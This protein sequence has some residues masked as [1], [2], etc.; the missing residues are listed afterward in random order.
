MY[1]HPY[2]GDDGTVTFQR[3]SASAEPL[4]DPIEF[5]LNKQAG[6]GFG[7]PSSMQYAEVP[8]DAL[9]PGFYT[10]TAEIG[11][12]QKA[13]YVI[14]V[15]SPQ[16]PST[17]TSRRRRTCRPSRPNAPSRRSPTLNWSTRPS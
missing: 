9:Q 15:G 12:E 10:V 2:K 1:G 6:G 7:D 8:A 4:G 14:R 3:L 17:R 16:A 5:D 11:D 13:S